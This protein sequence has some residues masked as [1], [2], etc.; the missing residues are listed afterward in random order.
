MPNLSK[1]CILLFILFS[2]LLVILNSFFNFLSAIYIERYTETKVAWEYA[3]GFRHESYNSDSVNR[4]CSEI[5][6]NID[7]DIKMGWKIT[8]SSP[9]ERAVN[10]G[11]CFGREIVFRRFGH[12]FIIS[13]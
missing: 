11:T 9:V 5:S 1:K 7:Y 13:P 10:G 6:S 12:L 8:S 3:Y 4:Q 2:S